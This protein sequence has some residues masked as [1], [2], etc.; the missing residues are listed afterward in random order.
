MRKPTLTFE[1]TG[2]A[3]FD[4]ILGGGVPSQSVVIIGGEP[5]SGKTV[6]TLQMLFQAARRGHRCMY[7]TTLSEPS[8][9]V[10]RYMQQF[11]FF[12][13]ER[14]GTQIELFDLGASLRQGPRH[15]LGQIA[16]RVAATEPAFVAVDSFKALAELLR[17]RDESRALMYDFAVQMA[18]W[19]ATTFLV[20]EYARTEYAQHAEFAIADGIIFLG[21]DREGLT[22]TR[23]LEIMKLR[24]AAHRSGRHFFD[25]DPA[26]VKVF[27]RVGIPPRAEQAPRLPDVAKSG[28]EGLDDLLDGG[29]P[30]NSATLVQGGTGTGKTLLSMQF[31]IEGAKRGERGMLFTLEENPEQLRDAA[32]SVGWDL[33]ALERSGLLSIHFTSAIELSTDRFL[34]DAKRKIVDV[35][36][37]RAVFDSLSTMALGLDSSRRFKELV[38]A[39]TKY[40]RD[41]G[42]TLLMTSEAAELLG[43]PHLSGHGASYLAD[44][45]IQ[46]R[47]VELAG[48]LERAMS[49]IKARGVAHNT[50]L[51]SVVIGQGGLS[52]VRG[53]FA[54]MRGVLTGLPQSS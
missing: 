10:M 16:D 48:R 50:E 14:F 53:R 46:I 38:Y 23:S 27:P 22:S 40:A 20:G 36:A 35:G 9:K 6:L 32:R 18:G 29:F 12:D 43:S 28:I 31:L 44:T 51:R 2:D 7:F 47:Y 17:G 26:G 5:G 37:T 52:I 25:I 24:G 41:A 34:E 15:A 21:T 4:A 33:E 54:D 19:G 30:R 3:A 13:P 45:L 1:P 42:V 49:V 8:I 11:T 39:I